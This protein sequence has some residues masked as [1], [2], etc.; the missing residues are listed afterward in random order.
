MTNSS[1]PNG[2]AMSNTGSRQIL[3]SAT[4]ELRPVAFVVRSG[5]RTDRCTHQVAPI[6]GDLIASVRWDRRGDDY[7]LA[8][9]TANGERDLSA[10]EAAHTWAALKDR[11]LWL[12]EWLVPSNGREESYLPEAAYGGED[13]ASRAKRER[14]EAAIRRYGLPLAYSG[15]WAISPKAGLNTRPAALDFDPDSYQ[16]TARSW[17]GSVVGISRREMFFS[18]SGNGTSATEL[19][20]VL[21]EEHGSNYA[22]ERTVRRQGVPGIPGWDSSRY[23]IRVVDG[24]YTR[25]HHSYGVRMD[26]W[27]TRQAAALAA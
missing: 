23:L 6:V 2:S 26:V 4:G 3:F 16:A 18:S 1:F 27:D 15:E 11:H 20:P 5:Y 12:D 17:A 13:L 22:H 25:D 14:C 9:V 24:A 21:D 19:H 8:V 10:N 7:T